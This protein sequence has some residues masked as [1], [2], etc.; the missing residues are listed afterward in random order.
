MPLFGRP[1]GAFVGK[2][3]TLRVLM[4]HLMPT[5]NESVVYFDQQLVLDR[6]LPWAKER[7]VT[8]FTIVLASIVRAIGK[9][10]RM[11]RFVVG[12][13]TYQRRLVEVSF[14]VKKELSDEGKMTTVKVAFEPEDTLGRVDERV[15]EAV[16]VGRGDRKTS[17]EK[18]MSVVTRLPRSVL[19]MALSLQRLLDYFNL[20]PSTMIANDPLYASIFVAN[21][22]SVGL[23]AAYHHLYEYGTVPL[24][25][26]LGRTH[27][28]A[29]VEDGELAV[30]TVAQMRYT[31]DER[32]ADGYYAARTLELFKAYV[33]D[34]AQ[35]DDPPA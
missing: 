11:N 17:S 35:L 10:P 14:A 7:G 33:E 22:G 9:R 1:D 12:R 31:F 15:R 3:P 30:R 19:R 13:R 18:E 8:L 23:D 6:T 4:P 26:V 34:P 27:Q 16:G 25:A 32:I 5:R 28:A 29:V 20:L 24:F 2:L 21:L